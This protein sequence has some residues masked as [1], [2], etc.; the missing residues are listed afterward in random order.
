MLA[1]NSNSNEKGRGEET[2]KMEWGPL[3]PND[4]AGRVDTITA[5][6]QELEQ[7]FNGGKQ[8]EGVGRF[9]TSVEFPIL[10]TL[11]GRHQS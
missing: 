1:V 9:G 8:E 7:L 11:G 4:R 6:I 3:K 2:A 5:V 10:R